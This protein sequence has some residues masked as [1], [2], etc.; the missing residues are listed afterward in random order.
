MC[1][2]QAGWREEKE[3]VDLTDDGQARM[4]AGDEVDD[5]KAEALR[6]GSKDREESGR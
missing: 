2:S 3:D 4:V 5:L 6:S 1:L